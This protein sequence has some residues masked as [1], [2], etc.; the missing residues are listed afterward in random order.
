M[1]K[2]QSVVYRAP[3]LA[4][5]YYLFIVFLI[6]IPTGELWDLN[7]ALMYISLMTKDMEY[8]FICLLAIV[9]I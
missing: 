5:T 1:F 3:F 8:V 4:G 2:F 9:Q 6:V 7:I